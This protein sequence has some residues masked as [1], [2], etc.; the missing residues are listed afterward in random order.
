[1]KKLRLARFGTGGPAL[2]PFRNVH[3]QAPGRAY[4]LPMAQFPQPHPQVR[5]ARVRLTRPA[6]AAI[7]A[8]ECG[9]IHGHVEALSETGGRLQLPASLTAGAIVE[10]AVRVNY[11]PVRGLAEMLPPMS[12]R[13][14]AG[15][16]QPFRFIALGDED[17]QGLRRALE[18]LRMAGGRGA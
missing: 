1:M 6:P 7:V 9:T 4:W 14:G 15:C 16:L 3:N 11:C 17:H 5:A 13:A 2:Q 12:W 10:L 18:Q 8:G